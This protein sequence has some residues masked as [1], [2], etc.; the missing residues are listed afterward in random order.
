METP[1]HATGGWLRLFATLLAVAGLF[2]RIVAP[3][4]AEAS[5]QRS[6]I[7]SLDATFCHT[8]DGAPDRSP[9]DSQTCDHCS[10]CTVTHAATLAPPSVAQA[11]PA[12]SVAA[13]PA[14]KSINVAARPRAPPERSNRAR[15][16]PSV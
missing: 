8:G 14:P 10:L 12:L 16:P 2:A 5:D 7:A 13:L 4:P 1:R 11:L 9:L 15:A 3:L 6:D